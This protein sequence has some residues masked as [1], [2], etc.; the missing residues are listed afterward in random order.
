MWRFSCKKSK[1]RTS[2]PHVGHSETPNAL[3]VSCGGLEITV[4][5]LP[6]LV[7]VLLENTRTVVRRADGATHAAAELRAS[8]P[9]SSFIGLDGGSGRKATEGP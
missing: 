6:M 9:R 3:R 1:A 5:W 4:I 7:L 8:K 2:H